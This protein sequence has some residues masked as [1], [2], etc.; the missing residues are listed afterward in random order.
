MYSTAR[1]LP[2]SNLQKF[3][4]IT[5]NNFSDVIT[6]S[7]IPNIWLTDDKFV[8]SPSKSI[9]GYKKD[10]KNELGK[11]PSDIIDS[12]DDISD[13]IDDETKTVRDVIWTMTN[14]GFLSSFVSKVE[15]KKTKK[16]TNFRK[17]LTN[18]KP[19]K[20][21]DVSNI[22][23]SG[24]GT[25]VVSLSKTLKIVEVEGV[26]VGTDNL[27]AFLLAMKLLGGDQSVPIEEMKSIF[28]TPKTR[29]E[30]TSKVKG[31]KIKSFIPEP[32]NVVQRP[33]APV[34]R[35]SEK[36]KE[37]KLKLE[38]LK[39]KKNEIRDETFGERRKQ[40]TAVERVSFDSD[41]PNKKKKASPKPKQTKK[42]KYESSIESGS[43]SDVGD[44]E[45]ENYIELGSE[46]EGEP[47]EAG[48]N[49]SFG[50]MEDFV[51]EEDVPDFYDEDEPEESVTRFS[52]ENE[53]P[54]KL[55]RL[56]RK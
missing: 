53:E 50:S 34:R 47:E 46:D 8:F 16:P 7:Q 33:M 29:K 43:E 30:K 26:Q 6:A 37:K 18:T 14:D 36:R 23:A 27:D 32:E 13:L 45:P 5:K 28:K 12:R 10:I 11:L 40:E 55:K 44:V 41:K 2:K 20:I 15:T 1:V 3:R 39:N 19:N 42:K 9:G 38:E 56:R 51:T 31:P 52:F 21:R 22:D 4:L 25:K 35:F 24:K 49:Q 48:S 17:L 54:K